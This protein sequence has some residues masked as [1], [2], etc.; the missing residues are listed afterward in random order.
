MSTYGHIYLEKLNKETKKWEHYC[1]YDKDKNGEFKPLPLWVGQGY[2]RDILRDSDEIID[3][4]SP[5]VVDKPE[6]F[7]NVSAYVTSI[8]H[9]N[10][11]DPDE[12]GNKHNFNYNCGTM[13]CGQLEYYLSKHP[14]YVGCF[15]L[16]DE[17]VDNPMKEILQ[18]IDFVNHQKEEFF[19]TDLDMDTSYL[20]EYRIVFWCS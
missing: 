1:L 6:D 15:E 9:Q 5:F 13:T 11:S 20:N 4:K 8:Y 16:D 12:N 18:L 2:I 17:E 10:E 3:C 19:V 7:D 14:K